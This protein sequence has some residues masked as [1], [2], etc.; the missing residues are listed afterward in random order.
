MH[1]IAM[2]HSNVNAHN[3]ANAGIESDFMT[4]L[5]TKISAEN[6]FQSQS[7]NKATSSYLLKARRWRE[8][9]VEPCM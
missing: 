4:L 8:R 7:K 1:L 3:N 6:S 5:L 2:E 9:R